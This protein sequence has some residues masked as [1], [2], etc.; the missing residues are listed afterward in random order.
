MDIIQIQN[1]FSLLYLRRI[2]SNISSV[3][4]DQGLSSQKVA[5]TTADLFQDPLRDQT[6]PNLNDLKTSLHGN[7][8]F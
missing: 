4:P 5:H 8:Y 3:L 2:F 7:D 6:A 1:N